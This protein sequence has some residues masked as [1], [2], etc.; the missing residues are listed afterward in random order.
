MKR[1]ENYMGEGQVP[2]PI[3]VAV[4]AFLQTD[5]ADPEVFQCTKD[6]LE[7]LDEKELVYQLLFDRKYERWYFVG[8]GTYDRI[9]SNLYLMDETKRKMQIKR[10]SFYFAEVDEAWIRQKRR[11]RAN[12]TSSLDIPTDYMGI[13]Y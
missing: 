6:E 7:N 3:Q 8:A 10:A 5:P 13:N 4:S 11:E 1:I 12:G 2:R 9:R